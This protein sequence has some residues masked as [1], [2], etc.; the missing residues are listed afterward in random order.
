MPLSPISTFEVETAK[1]TPLYP[2]GGAREINVAVQPS[3]V[4]GPGAPS[5]AAAAV[6]RVDRWRRQRLAGW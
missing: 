6:C 2:N 3:L 5:A 4:T 1:L